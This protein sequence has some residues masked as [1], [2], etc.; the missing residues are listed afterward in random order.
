M[1]PL[2]RRESSSLEEREPL[3]GGVGKIA[4]ASRDSSLEELWRRE[5]PSL[6]ESELLP[7]GERTPL[8][9]REN[10]S[11]EERGISDEAL[12]KDGSNI[13]GRDR[14]VDGAPRD[15]RHRT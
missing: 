11:L 15:S 4:G 8:W 12:S 14:K 7:G 13:L 3:S 9:R 2:W 5:D 6:E 10:S 1:I